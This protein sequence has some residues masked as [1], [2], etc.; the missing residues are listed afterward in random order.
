MKLF[1]HFA[2]VGFSNT[3]LL[4][5]DE[6]GDALL[7][8][9]A[10]MDIQLL[11]LIEGNRYFI[12]HVLLTHNHDAHTDGLRTLRKIYDFD[13]YC[14]SSPKAPR[15][16]RKLRDGEPLRLGEIT[17]DPILVAGHSPDSFV[18]KI[19][20]MLFTGDALLAGKVGATPSFEARSHLLD[21]L[22][23][24]VASQ[25]GDLLVFPGHGPPSTMEAERRFNPYLNG[26]Y[27]LPSNTPVMFTD[28]SD[29]AQEEES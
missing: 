20:N 5:P 18:Y 24:K 2:V 11:R 1:L 13:I 6:G 8:D 22:H 12:R 19:G 21:A 14:G 17:V 15:E 23:N 27:R 9:P 16:S 7:I 26:T 10:V 28:L 4:G 25:T 3:Y 29:P